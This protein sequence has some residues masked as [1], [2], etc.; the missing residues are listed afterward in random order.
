MPLSA[1]SP[2]YQIVHLCIA[3]SQRN[4]ILSYPSIEDSG[5]VDAE[6]YAKA[7]IL[8]CVIDMRKGVYAAFGV[9]VHFAQYAIN[10]SGSAGGGGNFSGVEHI[11]GKGVIGLVSGTICD[12]RTLGQS[13]FGR[14]L[15]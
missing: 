12:G 13:G 10:N 8:G 11:Q 2:R 15:L 7:G 1:A 4:Y 6:Q 9:V 3:G 5:T 14:C